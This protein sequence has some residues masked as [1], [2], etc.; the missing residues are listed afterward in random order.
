MLL[1]SNFKQVELKSQ[2]P[3]LLS[4]VDEGFS[5]VSKVSVELAQRHPQVFSDRKQKWN[6][7]QREEQ[8]SPLPMQ[9]QTNLKK[10]L[11]EFLKSVAVERSRSV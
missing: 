4:L 5:F 7:K 1:T 2:F 10:L 6:S 11:Q 8:S 3:K 9:L